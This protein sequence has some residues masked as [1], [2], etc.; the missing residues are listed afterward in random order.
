MDRVTNLEVLEIIS[1]GKLLWNNIIRRRN[2]WIGHIMR[3]RGLLKCVIEGRV[4]GK[5]RRGRSRL[6][7]IQ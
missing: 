2:K 7:F 5:N 6:E 4:K 1:D 3:H